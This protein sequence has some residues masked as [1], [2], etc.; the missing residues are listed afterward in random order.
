MLEFKEG[1]RIGRPFQDLNKDFEELY[2]LELY[3][4]WTESFST[5]NIGI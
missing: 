2:I 3:S 5:P 4:F 1:Q